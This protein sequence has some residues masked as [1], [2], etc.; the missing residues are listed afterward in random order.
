MG[1]VLFAAAIWPF[2]LLAVGLAIGALLRHGDRLGERRH[3][4]LSPS[5][6]GRERRVPDG[7][8]PLPAALP[9]VSPG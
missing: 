6:R 4:F 7:G 2:V 3:P 1:M 8:G 9:G 5:S